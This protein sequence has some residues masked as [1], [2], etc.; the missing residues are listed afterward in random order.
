MTRH[1]TR[2]A[3]ARFTSK[4]LAALPAAARKSR[5]L[6]ESARNRNVV[7]GGIE[8]GKA[9]AAAHR[10][11]VGKPLGRLGSPAR[12]RQ[13]AR[14]ISQIAQEAQLGHGGIAGVDGY[15]PVPAAAKAYL[16]AIG[17]GNDRHGARALA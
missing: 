8:V 6:T 5:P 11:Q 17:Y 2:M 10:L 3:L 12:D 14:N 16:Q 15:T 7:N 13:I 4:E 1:V 9:Q